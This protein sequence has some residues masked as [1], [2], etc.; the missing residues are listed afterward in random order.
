MAILLDG[1]KVSQSIKDRVKKQVTEIKENHGITPSLSAILVGEK[2]ASKTYIRIKER[3]CKQVGI[4]SNI[5][6]WP[7]DISQQTL[8]E[9]IEELNQDDNTHGILV[10]LPL[11]EHINKYAII[12]KINP[13]KDVERKTT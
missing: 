8:E 12:D 4:R 7:S 3:A 1:V 2:S 9:K 11:P 6:Y 13:R 10:Q 5:K